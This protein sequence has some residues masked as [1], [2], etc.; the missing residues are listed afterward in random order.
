MFIH[1]CLFALVVY[2]FVCDCEAVV[3][4]GLERHD[5]M[6]TYLFFYFILVD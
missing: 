3:V 6:N 4:V 1:V 2:L 5:L